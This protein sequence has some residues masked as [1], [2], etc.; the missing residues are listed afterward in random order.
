MR[1]AWS[2]N[3]GQTAIHNDWVYWQKKALVSPRIES[4]CAIRCGV[5][6][7]GD[8]TVYS[9]GLPQNRAPEAGCRDG[10]LWNHLP[11]S[12]VLDEP[13]ILKDIRKVRLKKIGV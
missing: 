5:D 1:A 2:Y 10:F 7:V 3:S 6:L 9:P 8:Q 11:G 13:E 12:S 4:E